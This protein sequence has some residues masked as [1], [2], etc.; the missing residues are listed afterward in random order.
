MRRPAAAPRRMRRAG[1]GSPRRR[2]A[3]WADPALRLLPVW[4]GE[5]GA[6]GLPRLPLLLLLLLGLLFRPPQPLLRLRRQ[7]PPSAK[8][9]QGLTLDPEVNKTWGPF[10][11]GGAGGAVSWV[12]P[13]SAFPRDPP[14]ACTPA[15]GLTPH[16]ATSGAAT[17]GGQLRG[18]CL[19][20]LGGGPSPDTLPRTPF[21]K[22]L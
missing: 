17:S 22:P 6:C 14:L 1:A 19:A 12:S 11:C 18:L 20:F 15:W 21:L 7:V 10:T 9:K 13:A 4:E 8:A 3:L 5:D 2:A 16:L